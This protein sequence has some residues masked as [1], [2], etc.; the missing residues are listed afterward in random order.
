MDLD[1]IA[2]FDL[3]HSALVPAWGN[4][5]LAT[6]TEAESTPLVLAGVLLS[7]LAIYL[8]SKIGGAI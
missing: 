2:A 5:L 8:A 7:L 3:L 6:T 4:T 1:A